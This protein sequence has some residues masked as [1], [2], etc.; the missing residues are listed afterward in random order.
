MKTKTHE[1]GNKLKILTVETGNKTSCTALLMVATGSRY[2]NKKNNGIAH[3]F[4]HMAFKGSKNFK[5][6]MVLA[7]T[8]E[9]F[10]GVFN[11]FTS[12]EYTGYWIKGPV[13]HISTMVRVLADMVQYPILSREEIEREKGV[14]IEEIHMY[15][16]TP[17]SKVGDIYEQ[18]LFKDNPLGMDTIGT[19]QTVGNA[20]RTTF[21]DF[22]QSFYTP[23]NALLAIA[24]GAGN[25][26]VE[27][28]AGRSFDTWKDHSVPSYN[29]FIA[30]EKEIYNYTHKKKTEQSHVVTGFR[31][32][33]IKNAGKKRYVL[34]VLSAVLGGGMSSRLF[35]ELRE[36]RG[37][38]YYISASSDLYRDVGTYYVRA[39]IPVDK[40]KIAEAQKVIVAEEEKIITKKVGE[41]ELKRA[42]ELIK[43]HFLLSLEDT[44]DVAYFAGRKMLIEGVEANPEKLVKEIDAVSAEEVQKLAE[45]IFSSP[46]FTAMVSGNR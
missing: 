39:G 17:Q 18:I 2:E 7:S 34:S 24:G 3:F 10:G 9:G 6:A 20:T 19:A 16:D 36:R 25:D 37:L 1:L 38:C 42:K 31:T 44:F 41:E 11:A 8:V 21:T 33:G 46:R 12:K 45:E 5:N 15:E 30:P 22:I 43:G 23:G 29:E 27:E 14:I 28:V 35:H 26:I 13:S 40:I 32:F 4:E